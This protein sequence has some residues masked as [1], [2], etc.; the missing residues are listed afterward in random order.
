MA[1]RLR[2]AEVNIQN[3]H[4]L[5]RQEGF[6]LVALTTNDR[7]ATEAALGGEEVL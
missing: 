6:A 5:V 3:L 1:D 4:I 7:A 2:Q